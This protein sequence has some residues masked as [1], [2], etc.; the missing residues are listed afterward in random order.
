MVRGIRRNVLNQRE[1][2]FTLVELVVAMFILGIVLIALIGV[3]LSAMI[4]ITDATRRQQAT[5][6]ANEAM[7][8]LR[9]MPWDT[10]N[11][12]NVPG[13]HTANGNIDPYYVGTNTAGVVKVDGATY[14]VRLAATNAQDLSTPRT[15]LFDSFGS[16]HMVMSDPEKPG[17]TFDVRAYIV[18]SLD[19]T[20]GSV[21]LLV[22]ASW[23]DAKHGARKEI[24]LRSSAYPGSSGCGDLSVQPYLVSCQ[25]RFTFSGSSGVIS[26][27][28][29]ATAP[30]STDLAPLV[31]G[32]TVQE[33][34]VRAGQVTSNGE[35]VQVSYVDGKASRGGA[36][37]GS[38][39]V[40]PSTT[41]VSVANGYG[42][43]ST[44]A[45]DN[46]AISGGATPDQ[47]V[48]IGAAASS[49][50]SVLSGGWQAEAKADDGRSGTS[51]SSVTQACNGI[52]LFGGAPCTYTTLAGSSEVKVSLS[53]AGQTLY[54]VLRTGSATSTS[55]GGRFI[56]TTPGANYGCQT[57]G[58][59]GCASARST[60][61]ESSIKFGAF[62]SGSWIESPTYLVEIANY[63]D[64]V[65]A[66]R[67]ALQKSTAPTMARTAVVRFWNGSAYATVPLTATSNGVIAQ[68]G[69]VTWSP[70]AGV[71]V[72]ASAAVS[73]TPV[74]SQVLG[75]S[76]VVDCKTDT[77]AI[78]ATTGS[79]TVNLR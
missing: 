2:G 14:T 59:S 52:Q 34:S 53:Y 5:S 20:A 42:R 75:E 22:V 3:Q 7:E 49:A 72:T 9:A 32:S 57:L 40:A 69:T 17:V 47:L 39:P 44:A 55:G 11:K 18:N 21:G 8:T 33:L 41:G 4:T 45:S 46:Y 65:L 6:Y 63:S 27:S 36:T 26:T 62:T 24:A 74:T 60:Y 38:L 16:N 15:P 13:F 29:V 64:A 76:P 48:T 1:E 19:G 78:N 43:I 51:R 12:G 31:E 77:C 73:G 23:D 66:Q 67:G 30:D 70:A 79:V 56:S 35:S 25:D 54:P 68:S 37:K 61:D 58:G 28:L 50:T 10:L 71:T